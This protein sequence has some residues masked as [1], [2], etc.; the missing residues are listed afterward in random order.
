MNDAIAVDVL[1]AALT[2]PFDQIHMGLTAENVAR[3]WGI[4]R[5]DQDELAALSHRRANWRDTHRK[6]QGPDRPG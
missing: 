4:T 6:I 5:E 1:V 3:K 2:D